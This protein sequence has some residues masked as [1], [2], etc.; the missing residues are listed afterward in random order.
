MKR[1]RLI[2]LAGGA[3]VGVALFGLLPGGTVR[4]VTP[5]AAAIMYCF[6]GVYVNSSADMVVKYAEIS[7]G[8]TIAMGTPCAEAVATL[9]NAGF[10]ITAVSMP[11]YQNFLYSFAK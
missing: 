4:G 3:L 2:T 1:N 5:R 6:P 10:A 7:S 11:D 8:P 9:L